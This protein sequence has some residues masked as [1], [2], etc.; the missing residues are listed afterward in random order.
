MMLS[1]AA[2][3]SHSNGFSKRKM[4]AWG[5]TVNG[6]ARP[7]PNVEAAMVSVSERTK[8]VC[9]CGQ[10]LVQ[11]ERQ[12]ASSIYGGQSVYCD[13][14]GKTI[15]GKKTLIYHCLKGKTS[16]H[17]RNGYDL[18]LECGDKQ[19]QFDE[20]RGLMDT[21]NDYK[22]QR[23]EQYP[24]RVTLQYY[25]ATD[26]GA[27]NKEIMDDIVKQLEASQKQAD[28]MGSLV[29]EYDPKRPTEWID[30]PQDELKVDDGDEYGQIRAALEK[31]CGTDW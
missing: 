10:E 9:I 27:V 26:N 22:L 11:C 19:L 2:K 3:Q 1:S 17:H 31:H 4:S 5:G 15:E 14:C 20:L 30:K 21:V 16:Y 6:I 18:C 7:E 12:T 29:T 25:K 24:V 23:D 8:P 28:F 13:G